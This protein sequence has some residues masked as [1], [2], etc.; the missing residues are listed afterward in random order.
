MRKISVL[1]VVVTIL[2]AAAAAQA[3]TINP[4]DIGV[5]ITPVSTPV[6]GW[7]GWTGYTVTIATNDG[8]EISA[9]DFNTG[10]YGFFG[11][12]G[13]VWPNGTPTPIGVAITGADSHLIESAGINSW[14]M[15]SEDMTSGVL[16]PVLPL[17]PSSGSP[18][19][20]GTYLKGVCLDFSG[21]SDILA[22]YLN[23]ST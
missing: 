3:F 15:A 5:T 11:N 10:S 13:Q 18:E 22:A 2:A 20:V 17:P 9:L 8:S 1:L 7:N 16:P 23:K 21:T 19:G 14:E 4:P 6:P 12:L